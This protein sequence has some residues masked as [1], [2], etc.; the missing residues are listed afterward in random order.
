MEGWKIVGL[1]ATVV[2]T[3]YVTRIA[4]RALARRIPGKAVTS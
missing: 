3:V 2:V 4:K 1:L